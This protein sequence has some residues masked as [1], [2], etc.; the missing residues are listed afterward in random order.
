MKFL[1]IDYGHKNVGVAIS[2][3]GASFAFPYQVL[4]NDGKLTENIAKVCEQEKISK[5]VIGRSVNYKMEENPIMAQINV[6]AEAIKE[7]TNLEIIFQDE[8]LTS[9]EAARIIGDDDDLDARSAALILR[10]YLDSKR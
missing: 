7:K 1:G 8:T 2:D 6:F 3:E 4:K 9:R 10:N 5:V